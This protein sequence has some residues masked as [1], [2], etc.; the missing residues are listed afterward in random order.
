VDR[1]PS[2]VKVKSK[3]SKKSRP[4]HSNLAVIRELFRSNLE[5]AGQRSQIID[6][7]NAAEKPR[8][9]NFCGRGFEE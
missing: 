6:K 5:E 9:Q 1:L 8:R 4:N 3:F 7:K 2:T